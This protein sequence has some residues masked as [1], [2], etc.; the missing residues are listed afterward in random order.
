[1]YHQNARHTG[2]WENVVT[3]LAIG[4]T[5]ASIVPPGGLHYY[6]V[7]PDADQALLIELQPG[8]EADSLLL[9]GQLG[10]STLS[11]A[12]LTPNGTYE[13]L[14]SPTAAALYTLSIYGVDVGV[15][16]GAYTLTASYVDH[17]LSDLSP[18]IAGNAGE[19]RLEIIGLRFSEPMQVAL[20]GPASIGATDVAVGS[21]SE[22]LARFDLAGSPTGIYDV[23][24][25]WPDMTE[26]TLSGVF[27]IV[28]GTVL[29]SRHTW[30]HPRHS[31]PCV[32]TWSGWSTPTPATPT[33]RLPCSPFVPMS[34]S[35]WT[36]TTSRG[37]A[38][39]SWASAAP[40]ILASCASARPCGFRLLHRTEP[41]QRRGVRAPEDPDTPDPID[42]PSL[43]DGMR[44]PDM[45]PGV[46]DALWPD[47]IARL[48]FHLERLSPG[49]QGQRGRA[50]SWG[51]PTNDPSGLIDLEVL[52]AAG[53][54]HAAIAGDAAPR[55]RPTS[56]F[57]A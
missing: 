45:D 1:M 3:P 11:S 49:A 8:A 17:H 48:G 24:V 2:M 38:S 51:F 15:N 35:S 54:P 53:E 23:T 12:T 39:R 52:Q 4:E 55:R 26:R 30:S 9:Y 20:S 46:W 41:R 13:L 16:G 18:R 34:T 10:A 50:G 27:E 32:D 47:L 33:C 57:R 21:D 43:K 37:T 36:T 31:G 14:I 22:I 6:S 7:E 40:Q 42:W 19:T 29:N 5:V 44:P 28:A 56:C 25:T